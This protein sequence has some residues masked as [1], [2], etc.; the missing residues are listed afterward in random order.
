[1][2]DASTKQYVQFNA[3]MHSEYERAVKKIREELSLGQTYDHAC[4]AL[5]DISEEIKT[6]VKEDFLKI[7]IAEEHFGA[8][9]EL[10]DI[11]LFLELPYEKVEAAYQALHQDM[12]RETES[13]LERRNK[14]IN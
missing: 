13:H 1:M 4:D 7:I 9:I 3:V 2:S 8:G 5:T 10:S 12:V 6:F 14:K 11:A